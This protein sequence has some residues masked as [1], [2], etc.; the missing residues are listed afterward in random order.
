M[1]SCL[2]FMNYSEN[3]KLHNRNLLFFILILMNFINSTLLPF[4][5]YFIISILFVASVIDIKERI[6]P[7]IYSL[8]IICISIFFSK[9]IFSYED[10]FVFIILALFFFVSWNSKALGMGDVKLLFSLYLLK[11]GTFM[12]Q[13]FFNLSLITFFV[14]LFTKLTDKKQSSLALAPLILGAY[15]LCVRLI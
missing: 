9:I 10:I 5:D 15:L 4:E 8:L 12:F 1:I 7:N 14:A 13:L 3:S 11:G 6:I 2:L